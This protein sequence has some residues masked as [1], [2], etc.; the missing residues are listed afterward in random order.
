MLLYFRNFYIIIT[1]YMPRRYSDRAIIRVTVGFVLNALTGGLG[2][3]L[4]FNYLFKIAFKEEDSLF[5]T[6]FGYLI[7]SA[8]F[9]FGGIICFAGTLFCL[10]YSDIE[11]KACKIAFHICYSVCLFMVISLAKDNDETNI[12]SNPTKKKLN[13]KIEEQKIIEICN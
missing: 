4:Y 13:N 7:F 3:M 5:K 12:G 10:F 2:T 11:T 1:D 8:V 6:C 9:E